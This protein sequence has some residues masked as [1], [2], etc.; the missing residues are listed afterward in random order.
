MDIWKMVM[1]VN[2]RLYCNEIVDFGIWI[3]FWKKRGF[4]I[5]CFKCLFCIINGIS[6]ANV[7]LG[8]YFYKWWGLI[9]I[10]THLQNLDNLSILESVYLFKN[11]CFGL[12]VDDSYDCCRYCMRIMQIKT[13][14]L[15]IFIERCNIF[16]TSWMY[17]VWKEKVDVL[18]V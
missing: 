6:I 16:N 15:C 7:K 1:E 2:M 5:K 9:C 14:I 3:G 10:I 18:H 4:A 12:S 17:D 13:N 11:I 8:G